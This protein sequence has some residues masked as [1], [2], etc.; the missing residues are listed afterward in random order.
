MTASLLRTKQA[1][2]GGERES[3]HSK[4][5]LYPGVEGPSCPCQLG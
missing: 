3:R 4:V 2:L 1:A 5:H